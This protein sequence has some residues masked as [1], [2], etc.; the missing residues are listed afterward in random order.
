MA[1]I[2][3]LEARRLMAIVTVTDIVA[4]NRGEAT[5]R[6]S[7]EVT[8][9]SKRTVRL[10][11]AGPD[12]IANT[13]DDI[14]VSRYAVVYAPE[15]NRITIRGNIVPDTKYRVR[16]QA[17][18]VRSADG[19]EMLDGTYTGTY[20]TGDG[21]A[22]GNLNF[23]VRRNA[24]TTPRVRFATSAGNIDVTM[25][26][27]LAGIK[28]TVNNFLNYVDSGRLD[29]T[30][31][32]RKVTVGQD[33]SSIGIVQGGGFYDTDTA[34][35]VDSDDPIV[36]QAGVLSNT[37]GTIAM[38]RTGDPNSATSQFFFNAVANTGLDTAGG[39]YAAFGSVANQ[40][41]LNAL[42]VIY[43]AADGNFPAST[44]MDAPLINGNL[45][46]VRRIS[47]LARVDRLN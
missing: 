40:A 35:A 8:N 47:T 29:G 19:G 7:G 5:I 9:V 15:Q 21:V 46:V 17:Q 43:G 23:F 16:I 37:A 32:H 11:A 38:A 27:D 22:G 44:F 33:G 18:Q 20:P 28:T 31:I 26:G 6:L 12:E 42:N 1:M 14:L 25:R 45:V 41:S 39:G 4:D 13:D 36:L 3:G 34:K 2:E 10:Y 30:I 24:S